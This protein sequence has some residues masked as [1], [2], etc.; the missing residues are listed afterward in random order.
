M[1]IYIYNN[2][3]Y[4]YVIIYIQGATHKCYLKGQ[5]FKK[6]KCLFGRDWSA[7]RKT[8]LT[9]LIKHFVTRVNVMTREVV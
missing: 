9:L 1:N 4:I 8:L 2:E 5:S 6:E 3:Y 7:P